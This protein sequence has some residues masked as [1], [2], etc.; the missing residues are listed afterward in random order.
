[1]GDLKIAN[2]RFEERLAT[3][4]KRADESQNARQ[5]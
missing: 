5:G 1:M 4:D 3:T 2:A